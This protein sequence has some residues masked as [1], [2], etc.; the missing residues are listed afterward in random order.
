MASPTTVSVTFQDQ[1][2]LKTLPESKQNPGLRTEAL[3]SFLFFTL[4]PSFPSFL[5]T[6]TRDTGKV[7]GPL[8]LQMGKPR[9]SDRK[10]VQGPIGVMAKWEFRNQAAELTQAHRFSGSLK[11]L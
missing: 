7:A 6:S 2:P 10:G 4:P 8:V 5:N 11:S 9:P 1:A 3:S